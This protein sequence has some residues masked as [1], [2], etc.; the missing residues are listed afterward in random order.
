M[1]RRK[2]LF[3]IGSAALGLQGWLTGRAG[4]TGTVVENLRKLV[5]RYGFSVTNRSDTVVESA[6][7]TVCAPTSVC[8]NQRCASVRASGTARIEKDALGNQTALFSVERLAPRAVALLRIQAVVLSG[9]VSEPVVG[10]LDEFKMPD[11]WVQSGHPDIVAMARKLGRDGPGELPRRVYQWVAEHVRKER[12]VRSNL[13]AVY[14]LQTGR[15]DCTESAVLF[16]AL[17]RASGVPARVCSGFLVHDSAVLSPSRHHNWAEFH[18][19]TGWRIADPNQG[20]FCEKEDRYVAVRI[21]SDDVH[22]LGLARSNNSV[23]SVRML[24]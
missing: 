6:R 4:E 21:W 12:D 15:G 11:R 14:A 17:C 23:L 2:F 9:R 20:R 22:G 1:D 8:A 24:G 16:V 10:R 18:D 19:G 5:V 13:G 7:V 3:G